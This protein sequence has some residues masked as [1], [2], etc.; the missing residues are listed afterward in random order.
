[1]RGRIR[2][3]RSAFRIAP[4]V[5]AAW[6]IDCRKVVPRD[7]LPQLKQ[8]S[9]LALSATSKRRTVLQCFAART[10]ALF[11]SA[12]GPRARGIRPADSHIVPCPRR[13]VV[14]PKASWICAVSRRGDCLL[15]L[16]A[17]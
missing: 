9:H 17:A 4:C 12:F 10:V 6:N 13:Q 7:G 8:F 5:G 16:V 3:L 2:R 15:R 1:M 11:E 14:A